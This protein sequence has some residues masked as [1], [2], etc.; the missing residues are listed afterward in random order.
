MNLNERVIIHS[1]SHYPCA[2]AQ[3]GT[4]FPI[5]LVDIST[6][7]AMSLEVITCLE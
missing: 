5:I 7:G 2:R 6:M 1:L 3:G 4:A